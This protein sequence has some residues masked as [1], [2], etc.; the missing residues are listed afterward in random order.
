MSQR[1][2]VLTTE[3]DNLEGEERVVLEDIWTSCV[4]QDVM[5]T[6]QIHT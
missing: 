4:Y 5:K 2:V 1:Q 3:P 6:A